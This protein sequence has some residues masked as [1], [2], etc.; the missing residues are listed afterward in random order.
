METREPPRFASGP[1]YGLPLIPSETISDISI[2]SLAGLIPLAT[3][4]VAT[5]IARGISRHLLERLIHS[6]TT[7]AALILVEGLAATGR[8]YTS[9][10]SQ[11]FDSMR[12]TC[13][14]TLWGDRTTRATVLREVSRRGLTVG[15][16][17]SLCGRVTIKLAG[18]WTIFTPLH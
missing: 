6:R 17:W 1:D 15:R 5:A 9:V 14:P 3:T 7:K 12:T 2:I 10:I 11:L 4:L 16:V 13:S 18:R 8:T